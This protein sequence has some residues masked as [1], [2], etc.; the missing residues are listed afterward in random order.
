MT[1]KTTARPSAEILTHLTPPRD[2]TKQAKLVSLLSRKNDVTLEK[3][4]ET[5]SWQKHTTSATMTG[6]RKRGYAI[7]REARDSKASLYRI[8]ADV[9]LPVADGK[10]KGEAP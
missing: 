5:L 8:N 7:N 6:L 4:A 2:G 10:I 3:A 9:C 1:T